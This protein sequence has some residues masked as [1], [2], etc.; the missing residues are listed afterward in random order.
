MKKIVIVTLVLAAFVLVSAG[1][2]AQTDPVETAV[3]GC[4]TELK[5]YCSNVTPGESR[6]LACLYAHG[7]KLSGRCEYALYD[8]SMQLQQVINA[9][10]YLANQC[11]D[12]L[13]TFCAEVEMGEGRLAACLLE[14]E[15][16]LSERCSQAIEDTGLEMDE[17]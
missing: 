9:L 17:E 15:E 14:H 16:E 8:A 5:T 2:Q 12:D 11:D 3:T 13:E 4:E 6:L 1:V 10:A 7:D